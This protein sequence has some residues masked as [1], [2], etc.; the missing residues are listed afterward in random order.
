MKIGR[1]R[2]RERE[3]GRPAMSTA[4]FILTSFSSL[5]YGSRAFTPDSLVTLEA[6]FQSYELAWEPYTLWNFSN[7]FAQ[8]YCIEPHC[9]R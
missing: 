9:L 1:E 6:S 8:E 3:R 2:E 7:P 4:I 5:L